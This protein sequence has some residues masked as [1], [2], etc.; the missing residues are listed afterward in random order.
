MKVLGIDFSLN[1]T[2]LYLID[3]EGEDGFKFFSLDKKLFNKYPE[4][5]IFIDADSFKNQMDKVDWVCHQIY[6]YLT[7]ADFVMLEQQI[8]LSFA[9]ADG[10]AI[11]KYF[12]RRLK[13]PCFTIA[14]TSCKKFAGSGKADKTQMSFFLRQEK[15][16]DFDYLGDVANNVVDACWLAQVGEA[17]YKTIHGQPVNLTKER[18]ETVIKLLIKHGYKEKPKKRVRKKKE[19]DEV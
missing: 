2:G 6:N 19:D 3:T 17:I 18:Q 12:C 11:I 14:P 9:W 16:L 8:G 4:D 13:I 7:K 5:C 15:G 1:G 10:Y